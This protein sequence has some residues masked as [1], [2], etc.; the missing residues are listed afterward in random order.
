MKCR[1]Y[2]VNTLGLLAL[3]VVGSGAWVGCGD[4]ENSSTVTPNSGGSANGGTGG[5]LILAGA[6]GAT[7]GG[8]SGGTG[9]FPIGPDGIPIGFTKADI[10]A[11]NLGDQIIAGSTG[12]A[13]GTGGISPNCGS[14]LTGVVRDFKADGTAGGHPDFENF[15]GNGLQGIVEATLGDDQKPVYAHTGSTDYTTGPAE[16]R[17]WYISNESINQTFL[18]HFFL[19]QQSNGS[20]TFL[21]NAFFPLDGH[22]FGDQGLN[23]GAEPPVYHNYSFTTEVHTQFRYK[24][25]E[26]FRFVG[27]DDLWVFIN[28]KLAIDLG[29]L[30][31]VQSGQVN[32]DAQAAALGITKDNIY[33]LDLFHAERHTAHSNFRIDTNLEFVNCGTIIDDPPA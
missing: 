21:S 33:A 5:S 6:G 22:G 1:A 19:V 9:G 12:G 10:G 30:H 4:S 27:D 29:G 16:F 24:G 20:Y 28:G 15:T 18:I 17:Q 25:G 26:T 13:G 31:P 14:V 8:G 3:G 2:W 32:L 7:D 23:D 11:W